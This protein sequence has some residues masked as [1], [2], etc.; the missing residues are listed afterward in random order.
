MIVLDRPAVPSREAQSLV[1]ISDTITL[2]LRADSVVR[3]TVFGSLVGDTRQFPVMFR[4][5]DADHLT[6][7]RKREEWKIIFNPKAPHLGVGLIGQLSHGTIRGAWSSMA[8]DDKAGG[9]FT[10]RPVT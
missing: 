8:T 2:R 7:M 5:A 4:G 1:A 10:L 9:T 6:G 3:D